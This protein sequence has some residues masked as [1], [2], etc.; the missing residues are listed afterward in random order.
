MTHDELRR[1]LREEEGD[2]DA[3]R[4]RKRLHRALMRGSLREVRRASFVV[5]NPTHVAVA[6]RYAP[7]KTPVPEILVR[8]ADR[9]AQR[10]RLAAANAAIPIL[11]QPE[12]ARQLY[13]HD[14]LGPIPPEAY[15]AVAAIVAF[16]QRRA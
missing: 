13:A 10:V 8:A 4:R 16:V 7:P 2:P 9:Q 6:L 12:L 3:R 14:R 1:D 5:V 15:V 11:E